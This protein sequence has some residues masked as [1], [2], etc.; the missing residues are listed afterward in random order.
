[1]GIIRVVKKALIALT[2][3]LVLLSTGLYLYA[4]LTGPLSPIPG[5]SLTGTHIEE[6]PIWRELPPKGKFIEV[7]WSGDHAYSVT[8]YPH[9]V[10]DELYTWSLRQT[11][12]QSESREIQKRWSGRKAAYIKR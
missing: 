5:G 12:G 2:T 8:L 3:T 1:M 11:V 7:K 10:G 9:V 4:Q 6:R